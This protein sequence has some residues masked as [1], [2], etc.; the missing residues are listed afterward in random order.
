MKSVVAVISM[1]TQG[2][3]I[4]WLHDGKCVPGRGIMTLT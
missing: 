2:K 1:F 3:K 4:M